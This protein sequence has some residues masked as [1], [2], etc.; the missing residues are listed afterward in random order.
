MNIKEAQFLPEELQER[1]KGPFQSFREFCAGFD[2]F[3]HH[4]HGLEVW[5]S[6][7]YQ[8]GDLQGLFHPELM[9]RSQGVVSKLFDRVPIKNM[10]GPRW[11][12]GGIDIK[13]EDGLASADEMKEPQACTTPV[14]QFDPFGEVKMVFQIADKMYPEAFVTEED[15]PEADQGNV[16]FGFRER[17]VHLIHFSS[18]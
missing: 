14:D 7:V 17:D 1:V 15:V 2:S 11:F 13:E 8:T 9:A 3:R 18:V 6:Q 12:R 4:G 10:D 5:R 16:F